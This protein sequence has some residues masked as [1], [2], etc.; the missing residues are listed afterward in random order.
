MR[1]RA[2]GAILRGNDAAADDGVAFVENGRL[3]ARDAVGGLVEL[4]L[5][6]AGGRLD[7]R[8]NGRR[9]VAELGIRARD[10]DVEATTGTHVAARKCL[11]W[12]DD[13]RVRGRFRV[14]DVERCRRR[15]A[16]AAPLPGREP[17]GAGVRPDAN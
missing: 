14:E 8:S 10:V 5:E 9:P 3:P 17:P 15:D 4:Q 16:D 13:D 11:A 2:S 1:R 7:T 6:P 12:P